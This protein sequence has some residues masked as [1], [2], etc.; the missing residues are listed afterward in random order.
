M[1]LQE[2]FEKQGNWLF[3][4]RGILPLIVFIIG[5]LFQIQRKISPELFFLDDS[6]LEPYY[7]YFCFIISL[8]GLA[9]R[10]YTLGFTPKN[11]SGGNVIKQVASELNTSGSYSMVRH[12]LYVGNFL[13]WLGPLLLTGHLWFLI[14]FCLAYWIYYER[15]MFA[16]EQ[17]LR[18]KFGKPYLEWAEQVPP[19][20]PRFKAFKKPQLH[21]SWKKILKKEKNVFAEVFLVFLLFDIAGELATGGREINYF[22]A[23]GFLLTALGYV[24]IKL[25]K[26]RT[27]IL[28]DPGR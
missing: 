4:Y 20:L 21:F 27:R 6:L 12:P 24:V 17:F 25:L 26:N 15:I 11:T 18:K 13:M 3:R 1:A 9:I 14:L 5:I 7:P 22:F 19:F 16:E 8:L 10:V 2:E 23:G 28:D